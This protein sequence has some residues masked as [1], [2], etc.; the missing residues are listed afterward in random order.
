M[1]DGFEAHIVL[2]DLC[3]VLALYRFVEG[4]L[5]EPHRNQMIL[6]YHKESTEWSE[7]AGFTRL[8]THF[9]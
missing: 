6:K 8:A 4:S 5:N 9:L 3:T 1:I 7:T 2:L